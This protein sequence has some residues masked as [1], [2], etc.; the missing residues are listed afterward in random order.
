M[1]NIIYFGRVGFQINFQLACKTTSKNTMVEKDRPTKFYCMHVHTLTIQLLSC[2]N[3][4]DS[5]TYTKGVKHQG[6]VEQ[7]ANYK[8]QHIVGILMHEQITCL[9]VYPNLIKKN[10]QHCPYQLA[11]K[12]LLEISFNWFLFHFNEFVCS[13][14]LK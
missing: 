10:K 4:S 1:L 7:V 11:N 14:L 5:W 9:L 6:T 8:V 12:R 2:Q 13:A 3:L